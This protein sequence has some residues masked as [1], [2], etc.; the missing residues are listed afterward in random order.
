V[1]EPSL[2]SPPSV[3]SLIPMRLLPV[4]LSVTA[5]LGAAE[6]ASLDHAKYTEALK[7]FRQGK[8]SA[9]PA[10]MDPVVEIRRAAIDDLRERLVDEP[11]G[12][13]AGLV[14]AALGKLDR[15]TARL[16]LAA[17]AEAKATTTAPQVAALAAQQDSPLRAEAALALA[18]IGGAKAV[19]ILADL[20]KDEALNENIVAALA[21][22]AGPGVTDAFNAGIL[23]AKLDLAGRTAL[24]KAAIMRNNRAVSPSLCAVLT[25]EPL[26][27]EAQKALLKLA[28][29]EDIPALK[30]AQAKVANAAT[31]A[32]LERLIAKL[33]KPS[34]K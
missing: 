13:L 2:Y 26:R 33:E 14:G 27:L 7:S 9:L 3:P 32:A 30:A 8:A 5:L 22:T 23:D 16:L 10:L 34:D 31:K 18:E 21:K 29:P 6:T 24:I 11:A 17:L 28:R 15:E 19:P 20:A 25:D 4:L 1:P 12:H